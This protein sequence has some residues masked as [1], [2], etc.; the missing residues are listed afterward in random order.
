MDFVLVGGA[1]LA[2]S[3][4]TFLSG[5][6]L[7]TILMPVFALFFPVEVA[8]ALTA[9]VHFLNNIFKFTL[10]GG[11]TNKEVFLKFGLAAIPAAFGGAYLLVKLSEW[12]KSWDFN[13]K[14]IEFSIQP[15]TA[16]IGI[17]MIF[18]ALFEILPKMRNISFD[19]NKL[20]VGGL[21]SGFFGGLSG[22]QGA[23]RS[24][25]LIKTGLS[26]EGFIATGI[27]ISLI[28]D[29]VRTTIYAS[30]YFSKE[31]IEHTL[32]LIV[33]VGSAFTGAV[34]GRILLKKVTYD[35]IRLLVGIFLIIV[36]AGLA[37]G[38]I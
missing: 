30:S 1:A 32:L 20:W 15:V 36:G 38:I 5:F 29:V 33:A 10:I 17:V 35:S 6:G 21:I 27:T 24:A 22:H 14:G 26:K 8:I 9:I 23:M 28:V 34:I 4:L 13:L 19:R 2:A 11:K 37:A 3:L 31:L 7:G 16:I 12:Q 18:F 25:F